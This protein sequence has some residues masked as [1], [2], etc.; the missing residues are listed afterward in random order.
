MEYL[1]FGCFS[2][3]AALR[4]QSASPITSAAVVLGG[5]DENLDYQEVVHVFLL[6]CLRKIC[7][8]QN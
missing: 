5:A 3:I 4:N 2:W 1:L 7:T 8:G 6:T